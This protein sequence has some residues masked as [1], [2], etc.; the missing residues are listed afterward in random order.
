MQCISLKTLINSFESIKYTFKLFLIYG[1]FFMKFRSVA[2]ILLLYN[3]NLAFSS[4]E[5]NTQKANICQSTYK[6][7]LEAYLED[8]EYELTPCSYTTLDGECV[9]VDGSILSFFQQRSRNLIS[10]LEMSDNC[11]NHREPYKSILEEFTRRAEVFAD[12]LIELQNERRSTN[13]RTM[14][15]VIDN[16]ILSTLTQLRDL[17]QAGRARIERFERFGT[18]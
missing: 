17:V 11:S 10:T 13:S 16:R 6:A 12:E 18:L 14:R 8:M 5:I 2:F 1:R 7:I 15:R 9:E 4:Q 3:F